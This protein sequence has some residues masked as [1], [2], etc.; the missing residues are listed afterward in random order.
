MG[1]THIT[2]GIMTLTESESESDLVLI[3]IDELSYLD[4]DSTFS[5]A[6]DNFVFFTHAHHKNK[7]G[8]RITYI[9]V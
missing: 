3:N 9:I 1:E 2:S 7:I 5:N 6:F 4:M 8:V